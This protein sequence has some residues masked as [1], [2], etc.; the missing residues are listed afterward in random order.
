M[1]ELA[2]LDPHQLTLA[3]HQVAHTHARSLA[4]QDRK[5]AFGFVVVKPLQCAISRWR[6]HSLVPPVFS[7][8]I[9]KARSRSRESWA[10]T[11]E[12]PRARL[13]ADA[14]HMPVRAERSPYLFFG[15]SEMAHSI[16]VNAGRSLEVPRAT[17]SILLRVAFDSVSIA[18]SR[19]MLLTL[20]ETC[21]SVSR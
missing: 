19:W 9:C 4:P 11:P 18:S 10:D 15:D 14:G 5:R 17:F 2:Q 7:C 16:A 1:I 12:H 8:P 20:N 13:P 3:L 21:W 6:R